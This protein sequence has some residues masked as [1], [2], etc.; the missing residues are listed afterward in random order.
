M[1]IIT[2]I[3]CFF[4]CYSSCCLASSI[5]EDQQRVIVRTWYSEPIQ[6][7]VGHVSLEIPSKLIY[8]SL[9]PDDCFLVRKPGS[10]PARAKFVRSYYYDVLAMGKAAD[11]VV[12][13]YKFNISRLENIVKNFK[14]RTINWNFNSSVELDDQKD[15]QDHNCVTIVFSALLKTLFKYPLDEEDYSEGINV[16][17]DTLFDT[18]SRLYDLNKLTE[19]WIAVDEYGINFKAWEK[20][21][22]ENK[23]LSPRPKIS[24]MKKLNTVTPC[25]VDLWCRTL[26]EKE[27][28]DFILS[29]I[30]P[31]QERGS[32]K[33]TRYYF[34][35]QEKEIDNWLFSSPLKSVARTYLPRS[36]S[37]FSEHLFMIVGSFLVAGFFDKK[38][39]SVSNAAVFIFIGSIGNF[40]YKLYN[41]QIYLYNRWNNINLLS[42]DNMIL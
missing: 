33:V 42:D 5:C 7:S 36:N 23:I 32:I 31:Y 9:W 2:Y 34:T 41:N 30:P 12:C 27:R 39:E 1:A 11:S 37:Y 8:L 38:C 18:E 13:L 29:L 24:L 4:L 6:E 21:I 15:N 14:D 26:R 22:K 20:N 40:I 17:N 35:S 25:T 3:I 16:V 19:N 28:K 10:Q